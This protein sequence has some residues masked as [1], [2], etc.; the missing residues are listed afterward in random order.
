[1]NKIYK[2]LILSVLF[3]GLIM[4]NSCSSSD[5]EFAGEWEVT[6]NWN[7]DGTSTIMITFDGCN[8]AGTVYIDGKAVGSYQIIEHTDYRE[9]QFSYSIPQL[10]SNTNNSVAGGLYDYEYNGSL[11]DWENMSGGV[12]VYI[13]STS[14]FSYNKKVEAR[15]LIKS[16]TWKGKK[17]RTN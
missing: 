3:F 14:V 9:I 2:I 17:K 15:V 5:G 11:S 10:Y 6:I 13:S 16:G 4:L 8:S 12:D 7:N 1:M